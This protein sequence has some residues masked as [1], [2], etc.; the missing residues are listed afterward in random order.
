MP[1]RWVRISQEV[2]ALISAADRPPGLVVHRL[3]HRKIADEPN[4]PASVING[5]GPEEIDTDDHD[6]NQT[7]KRTMRVEHRVAI[8][9]DRP[10]MDEVPPEEALDPLITWTTRQLMDPDA[11][12]SG[13]VAEI[14]EVRGVG[15]SVALEKT[16]AGRLQEFEITYFTHETDPEAD[17]S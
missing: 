12:A 11:F 15:D 4:L 14:R 17:P 10:D 7:R 2:E 1:S 9:G 16:Y 3:S 6:G 8:A 13:L 5:N